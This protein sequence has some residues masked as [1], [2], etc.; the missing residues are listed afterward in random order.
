MTLRSIWSAVRLVV[1]A[2][3]VL[4]IGY[5][6]LITGV[7]SAVFPHQ[8]GGSLVTSNGR[9]VGSRLIGQE[10][11]S[12]GFFWGRPSATTPAYNGASSAASNLGP[13]N[14][15]LV[16]HVKARLKAFL[17]ANPGVRASQV[18]L[19]LLESSGSGLDPDITPAA[20]LVQVPRVA[21]ADHVSPSR[22]RALIHQYT[23]GR[24]LG[25]FGS[26]YVNVLEL[27]VAVQ[28][29]SRS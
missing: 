26:S 4:G 5:T 16:A 15:L 11:T 10:F 13:T 12:P 23:K 3:L 19:S 20:A 29:L 2:S 14:S 9:V 22:L 8:A 17:K 25:I 24:F 28:K 7:A 21:R 27:N 1:L 18:P 6:L